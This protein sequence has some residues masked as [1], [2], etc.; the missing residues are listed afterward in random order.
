MIVSLLVSFSSSLSRESTPNNATFRYPVPLSRASSDTLS[1]SGSSFV[2]S[3]LESLLA[4]ITAPAVATNA[5][6]PP[7]MA[8]I[9]LPNDQEANPRLLDL[10]PRL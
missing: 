2:V 10:R 6:V 1:A 4:R 3:I 7:R 9:F 5:T 8:P